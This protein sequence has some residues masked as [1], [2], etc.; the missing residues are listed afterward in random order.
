MEFKSLVGDGFTTVTELGNNI[1]IASSVSGGT[2]G[3]V[4]GATNGLHMSGKNVVLGG[5]LTGDTTINISTH[6][7][8]ITGGTTELIIE[9]AGITLSHY[10]QD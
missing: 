4:T 8:Q 1:I 7:L 3:L 2:G 6:G 9:P 5:T 10:Y